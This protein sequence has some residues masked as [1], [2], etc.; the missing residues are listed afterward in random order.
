MSL[1][2]T[3]RLVD[4]MLR[5]A[6][7][8]S[9]YDSGFSGSR[10]SFNPQAGS[11]VFGLAAFAAGVV[12]NK[13]AKRDAGAEA[14]SSEP[15][16]YPTRSVPTHT[17]PAVGTQSRSMGALLRDT[18]AEESRSGEALSGISAEV[19]KLREEVAAL[20]AQREQIKQQSHYAQASSGHDEYSAARQTLSDLTLERE[21]LSATESNLQQILAEQRAMGLNN[22][23]YQ[24]DLAKVQQEL[25]SMQSEQSRIQSEQDH[26]QR[27]ANEARNVMNELKQLLAE[28]SNKLEEAERR[29]LELKRD[30]QILLETVSGLKNQLEFFRKKAA[31]DQSGVTSLKILE[32]SNDKLV[33]QVNT[34]LA[35][36]ESQQATLA[37]LQTE[38]EHLAKQLEE[39]RTLALKSEQRAQEL[40]RALQEAKNSEQSLLAEIDRLSQINT[41]A[42]PSAA[43]AQ[44]ETELANARASI[45]ALEE[46]ENVLKHKLALAES[47]VPQTI[48]DDSAVRSLTSERDDLL[49]SLK[50]ARESLDRKDKNFQELEASLKEHIQQV[51]QRTG[52]TKVALVEAAEKEEELSDRISALLSQIGELEGERDLYKSQSEVLANSSAQGGAEFKALR[53]S[54]LTLESEKNALNAELQRFQN[55]AAVAEQRHEEAKQK[56]ASSQQQQQAL[57]AELES[58][59][60][61]MERSR[62]TKENF[63]DKENELLAAQ[64]QISQLLSEKA[65]KEQELDA[66]IQEKSRLDQQLA[67]LTQRSGLL[68]NEEQVSAQQLNK[69]KS[70]LQA[71]D[72][73]IAIAKIREEHLLQD[74]E[75]LQGTIQGLQ[76]EVHRLHGLN[77]SSGATQASAALLAETENQ[78]KAQL[79]QAQQ[80]IEHQHQQL[81]NAQQLKSQL[82]FAQREE[83]LRLSGLENENQIL[84]DQLGRWQSQEK[85]QAGRLNAL[86]SDVGEFQSL[87]SQRSGLEQKHQELLQAYQNA[88]Q[89]EQT[90]KANHDNVLQQLQAIGAE[91]DVLARELEKAKVELQNVAAER[92]E[93]RNTSSKLQLTI[94]ELERDLVIQDARHQ[95]ELRDLENAIQSK[96]AGVIALTAEDAVSNTEQPE[97]VENTVPFN[98][99]NESLA[100]EETHELGELGEF[101]APDSGELFQS[102][103]VGRLRKFKGHRKIEDIAAKEKELEERQRKLDQQVASGQPITDEAPTG[104]EEED[105]PRKI[106]SPN[107]DFL[108]LLEDSERR[109]I[110]RKPV[111]REKEWDQLDE[112]TEALE[113][114]SVK[115]LIWGGAAAAVLLG[116]AG[117]YFWETTKDNKS[118]NPGVVKA[119]VENP[120]NANNGDTTD[121]GASIAETEAKKEATK[122]KLSGIIEQFELA[123]GMPKDQANLCRVPNK[124][125]MDM[126]EYYGNKAIDFNVEEVIDYREINRTDGVDLIQAQLLLDENG[127]KS[128]RIVYF[129]KVNEDEYLMDWYS[130]VRYEHPSWAQYLNMGDSEPRDWHLMLVGRSEDPED[131]IKEFDK[132]YLFKVRSWNTASTEVAGA[133]IDKSN[134]RAAEMIEILKENQKLIARTGS[135]RGPVLILRISKKEDDPY[136]VTIEEVISLD[137]FYAKDTND[138]VSSGIEDMSYENSSY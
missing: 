109:S 58:I 51:E 43:S 9:P 65:L 53:Q 126:K 85:A 112:E 118:N 57:S 134:P 86:T 72:S 71:R 122:K 24:Q 93:L 123:K 31:T 68:A 95:Q 67:D 116:G 75:A 2:E 6:A 107:R 52:N 80:Q 64:E 133:Y 100:K 125:L 7:A 90:L 76:S 63:S 15:E 32:D 87:E 1:H 101:E 20:S 84:R 12:V 27:E 59:R 35:E 10:P 61:S 99:S 22:S 97:Q 94:A 47:T 114:S 41:S 108:D 16:S 102:S 132:H 62:Q 39:Y 83:S 26:Y 40:D 49:S 8:Y 69:I 70:D 30:H 111:N 38:K 48:V 18:M 121:I 105:K 42:A 136:N 113:E 25:A 115:P 13:I 11:W 91:R 130:F 79:E 127:K 103:K 45:V 128:K 124:T 54:I 73:D 21:K 104:E 117:Y 44:L 19:A 82:E 89:N 50:E 135:K 5:R 33:E 110:E 138:E 119:P 46:S 3:D 60:E 96:P 74:V 88:Q 77:T 4:A 137:Q 120:T 106:H 131:F 98:A 34:S 23:V 29:E 14:G 66:A 78:L 55:Q 56:L 37:I 81:L 17:P 28:K 129:E 36:T 92:D